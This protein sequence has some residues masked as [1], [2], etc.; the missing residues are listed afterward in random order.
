[1]SQEKFKFAY[2]RYI[3]DNVVKIVPIGHVRRFCSGTHQ[4]GKNYLVKWSRNEVGNGANAGDD[5]DS[6]MDVDEY[7]KAQI[8]MLS[9]NL[10]FLNLTHE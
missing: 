5:H 9:G 2:V 7:Y 1:M 8:V 3:D 10:N 6:E 4:P